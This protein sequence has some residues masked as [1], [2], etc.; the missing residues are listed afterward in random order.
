MGKTL[1]MV[2]HVSSV[3]VAVQLFWMILKMM[4]T[5]KVEK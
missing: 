5:M 3:D 4:E 1:M 2:L